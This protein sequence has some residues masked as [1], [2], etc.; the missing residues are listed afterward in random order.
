MTDDYIGVWNK[1]ED[2]QRGG[3]GE[4]HR[5]A[6]KATANMYLEWKVE[7][8]GLEIGE[9]AN[10][11][12]IREWELWSSMIMETVGA[13]SELTADRAMCFEQRRFALNRITRW[14]N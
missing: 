13:L 4:G 9:N 1:F 14:V 11:W 5:E 10:H 3:R 6:A 8:L 2:A 12:S 7:R